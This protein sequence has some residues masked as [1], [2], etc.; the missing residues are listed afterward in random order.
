MLLVVTLED[1]LLFEISKEHHRFIENDLHFLIA[2]LSRTE[3]K[4]KPSNAS[5][6]VTQSTYL[7]G[8]FLQLVVDEQREILGTAWIQ[9]DEI[10]KVRIDSL[11]RC[12][13]RKRARGS[14]EWTH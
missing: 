8:T 9:I 1:V 4:K 13:E 7:F 10:F 2:E 14:S 12:L 11:F 3:W 6:H 5:S